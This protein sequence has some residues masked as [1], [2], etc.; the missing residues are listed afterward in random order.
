[1]AAHLSWTDM[2]EFILGAFVTDDET[3]D[4]IR[5]VHALAGYVLDPHS[6]VGWTA[7]D[8]LLERGLVSGPLGI[9]STAHPA[10]FAETVEPLTGPIPAPPA[11]AKVMERSPLS[12]S[13]PA[14]ICVLK[15]IL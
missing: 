15:E 7:A 11:L 2:K 5:A 4:T 9:L 13:I 3:R 1:M 12:R 10:K 6:S 8:K 14:D